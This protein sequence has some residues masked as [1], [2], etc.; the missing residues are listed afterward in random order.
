MSIKNDLFN[1]TIVAA[2]AAGGVFG[3]YKL[4]DYLHKSNYPAV[5][6][7]PEIN[8]YLLTLRKMESPTVD[9][10][11]EE[12]RF[13]DSL[14]MSQRAIVYALRNKAIKALT[15]GEKEGFYTCV[16]TLLARSVDEATPVKPKTAEEKVHEAVKLAVK[17]NL[18]ME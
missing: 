17:R 10:I 15:E 1:W 14:H 9:R 7:M 8:G 4:A 3:S 11:T 5:E 2:F 13:S 16:D 12:A 18:E 6:K